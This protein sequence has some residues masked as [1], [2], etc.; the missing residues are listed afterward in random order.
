MSIKKISNIFRAILSLIVIID[1]ILLSYSVIFDLSPTFYHKIMI[2]DIITCM[3]LVFDFFCGFHKSNDKKEY[4]KENWI[5]LIVAIPFDIILSPV[6]AL[7]FL[8]LIKLVRILL[9]IA[10]FFKVIGNFLKSTHLDEI[11]AVFILI[12]IGSTF[13]LYLIDPSMNNIFDNLWFVVVSLT[14]VGYGDITPNTI[15]GK[16]LSLVLL[17][18]G[19]F[20]FSAITGAISTHFIDNLL[21]EGTFYITELNEKMDVNE[22]KL[23]DLNKQ[24]LKNEQKIDELKDEINELKEIIQKNK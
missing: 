24:V 13:G 14:T 20:I 9:F 10:E 1:V 5:E 3:V 6:L 2:F 18:V 7:R 17:I 23:D 21:Q 19:V 8:K 15:Y 11:L 12:I 4:V 22:A 16:M